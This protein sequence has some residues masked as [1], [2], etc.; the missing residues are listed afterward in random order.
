MHTIIV[1]AGGL[2]LLGACALAAGVLGTSVAKAALWFVPLWLVGAS[3]NMWVG[4]SRAGYTVAQEF[5]IFL[6]VFGVP[7]LVALLVRWRYGG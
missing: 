1:I 4:V 7:T 6:V 5:P 2:V 3:I